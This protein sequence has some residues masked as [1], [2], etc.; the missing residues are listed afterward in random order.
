LAGTP[1]HPPG[2]A[3]RAAYR[4]D[5]RREPFVSEIVLSSRSIWR[6]LR[7][8]A[9]A[10]APVEAVEAKE[11]IAGRYRRIARLETGEALAELDS[12][13]DGLTD[14][15]AARRLQTCGPNAV[16]HEA[17]QSILLQLLVRLWSPL[18]VMLLSL[19]AGSAVLREV[20][21]AIMIAIMVVLSVGLSF[22]QEYRIARER[23]SVRAAG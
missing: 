18:N 11:H 22:I 9:A 23:L 21:A 12:A 5:D 20:R 7:R 4:N 15:G 2:E 17:R 1:P 19:A 10:T 3:G 13:A 14:A 16:A 8:G 6:R